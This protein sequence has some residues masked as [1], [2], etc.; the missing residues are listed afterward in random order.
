MKPQGCLFVG[1]SVNFMLLSGSSKNK[2]ITSII[3][4]QKRW[5]R[6][7]VSSNWL[8]HTDPLFGKLNIL[9]FKDILDVN[10][11]IFMH[12]YFNSQLP[13]SF[14]NMFTPFAEPNRTKNFILEKP[15]NKRLETF[16]KAFLPKCWNVLFLDH[17]NT[18]SHS[19]L[20]KY[21]REDL[22]NEYNI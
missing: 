7:L 17:K 13:G 1:L 6:N 2:L 19:S 16:P 4:I 12:K 20:K 15:R 3:K 9:K 10:S 18:I 8:S 14:N 21:I 11:K 22:I 5:I